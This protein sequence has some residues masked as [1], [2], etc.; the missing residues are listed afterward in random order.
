MNNDPAISRS[1]ACDAH[2]LGGTPQDPDQLAAARER[3]RVLEQALLE[4]LHSR[5]GVW[6]LYARTVL[7][8]RLAQAELLA[9]RRS[10]WLGRFVTRRVDLKH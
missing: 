7:A 5:S 8:D 1:T 3:I 4:A 9:V 10:G 2:R 6:K